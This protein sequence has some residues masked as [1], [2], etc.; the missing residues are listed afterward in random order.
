MKSLLITI[1]LVPNSVFSITVFRFAYDLF[2]LPASEGESSKKGSCFTDQIG[3]ETYLINR[4]SSSI[5]RGCALSCLS[6]ST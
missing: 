6:G 5:A 2:N 3:A 4:L 1:W